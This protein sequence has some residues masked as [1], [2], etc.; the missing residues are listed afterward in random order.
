M[1]IALKKSL[2]NWFKDDPFTQSAAAAY[3]AIFS[4][5]GL[6]IILMAFA[7]IFFDQQRVEDEVLGH[8]RDML[9]AN[10]AQNVHQIVE[11]T[12]KQNRD[13]WAMIIG[14]LT[15]L[16]GATGLFVQL[17]R[18][19]NRIW[20]VE[21]KKSAGWWKFIKSRLISFSLILMIGFLLLISLTLTA[22][23]TIFGEWISMRFSMDSARGLLI[24]NAV[25]SFVS[26]SALFSLIFKILPDAKVP[27][28]AAL[29]GGVLSTCLFTVGEYALSYYF[30]MAQPD[31]SFGAAG[32]VILL[33]LWVSYSCMILLIGA[34]FA[35]IMAQDEE[36][37]KAKST[38][39]SKKK[40]RNL[41]D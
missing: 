29:K 38:D 24:L 28:C 11:E 10:T 2:V 41:D 7:A 6:L 9:G 39:I 23:I 4:L 34:E 8:I 40:L 26:I 36:G 5:P 22:M 25:F 18:S 19:L 30:E 3:Y 32:S 21:V 12:Q 31:S 16:F 33:M 27:W 37:H 17:Q 1:M 15:L 13:I 35:K 20:E 14:A